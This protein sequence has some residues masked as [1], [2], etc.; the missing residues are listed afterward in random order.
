[1]RDILQ[2]RPIKRFTDTMLFLG[3]RAKL[4]LGLPA[5]DRSP[6]AEIAHD[7]RQERVRRVR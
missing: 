5:D 3:S 7:R 6:V 4:G 2:A 1:V